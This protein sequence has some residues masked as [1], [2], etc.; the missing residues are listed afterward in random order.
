MNPE[1]SS[2]RVNRNKSTTEKK[3]HKKNL[4]KLENEHLKIFGFSRPVLDDDSP[5]FYTTDDNANNLPRAFVNITN[6]VSEL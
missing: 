6:S 2:I 5:P 3:N 1:E 4:M